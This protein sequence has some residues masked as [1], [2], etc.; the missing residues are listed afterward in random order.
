MNAM[1]AYFIDYLKRTQ[2]LMPLAELLAKA[3]RG[4]HRRKGAWLMPLT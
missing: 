2:P 1:C 3:E 4:G